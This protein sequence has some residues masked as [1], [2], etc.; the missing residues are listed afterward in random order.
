MGRLVRDLAALYL[1]TFH[2]L[3]T[4]QESELTASQRTSQSVI[5]YAVSGWQCIQL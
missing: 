4:Q 1:L 2:V 5:A 3:A